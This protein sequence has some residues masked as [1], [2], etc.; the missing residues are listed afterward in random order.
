M[1]Y[2][3]KAGILS[4][5][6]DQDTFMPIASIKNKLCGAEKKIQVAEQTYSTQIF[7]IDSNQ[8]RPE[9]SCPHQFTLLDG[10]QKI[11]LQATP[12]YTE[13]QE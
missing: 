8:S 1:N 12:Y 11:I 10:Q 2:Q 3:L 7:P 9:G 5:F 6:S 4:P 13:E